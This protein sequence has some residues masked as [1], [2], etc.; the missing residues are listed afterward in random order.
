[1]ALGRVS[2]MNGKRSIGTNSQTMLAPDTAWLIL[3][4]DEWKFV[5]DLLDDAGYTVLGALS[6]TGTK[7]F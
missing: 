5:V 7:F 3:Q 2:V 1:M 6:A 4:S